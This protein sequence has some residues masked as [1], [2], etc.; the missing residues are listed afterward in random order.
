MRQ[1]VN[2]E[3]EC[4]NGQGEL[5]TATIQQ[6]GDKQATIQLTSVTRNS[7]HPFSI[8]LALA[9][10]KP[11]HFE[12]ALEKAT[13]LGVDRFLL[14]NAD[15][16]EKKAI[17]DNYL[18]RLNTIV[19]SATKQCGR[20]FLPRIEVK[21]TLKACLE[22]NIFF[23]DLE[24]TKR[25]SEQT[26]PNH[27]TFVVGPEA[28]FSEKERT[29]LLQHKATGCLLHPN[30]LRAETAAVLGPALLFELLSQQKNL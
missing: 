24:S 11:S 20:L 3:I 28:G 10:L 21:G 30:T 16:S 9:Y 8:T 26:L 13:E 23:G 19:L 7:P 27:I 12:Y 14:F 18:Q 29:L 25:L 4:I 5:A 2:E 22:G 17:S 15:R 1:R 6:L